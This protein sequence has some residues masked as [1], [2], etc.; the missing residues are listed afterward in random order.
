MN[1]ILG[2]N[3]SLLD[4]ALVV[5]LYGLMFL[6]I[7]YPRP[8]LELNYRTNYF[9]LVILWA[10]L[11]FTGNYLFYR[12]GVMTFL[13]W[14]NN[15][16]HSCVWVGLCLGWL[17]YCAHERPLWEQFILFAFTSFLVK[18]AEHAVLGS[19]ARDSYL[20]IRNPYA[21]LVVMS[22][23][24]GFYPIISQWIIQALGR[25]STFGIYAPRL[26]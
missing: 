11:M 24:D 1:D 12:L 10:F 2:A 6:L 20:G 26:A 22:I 5:L 9:F 23:V 16:L 25:K 18:M 17:Y 19:W 7:R 8:H 21:Y 15:L 4:Y 14:L 3:N 13:P